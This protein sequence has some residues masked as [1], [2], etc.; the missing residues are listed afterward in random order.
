MSEADTAAQYRTHQLSLA[1]LAA[2]AFFASAPG[3]SF[4]IA[5]FVDAM[6]TGTGLS[7]TVFAS[8]YAAGT[9]ISAVSMLALGR[10]IDRRGLR[11]AW[12]AVTLALALACG[13][14]S[15][16]TGAIVAFLAL[17]ALRTSG[18]GSVPLLGTP[19]VAQ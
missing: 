13:L 5:V 12:T 19:L 6:L 4:L 14:A 10:I 7:R 1:A 11:A 18:Q 16:A 17:A 15:L 3:Q 2:V 9:V 8:L